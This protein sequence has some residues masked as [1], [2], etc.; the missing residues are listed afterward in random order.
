MYGSRAV[1]YGIAASSMPYQQMVSSGF[2]PQFVPMG[3]Q[4]VPSQFGPGY[5]DS[6][7]GRPA[8][9][10]GGPYDRAGSMAPLGY[11]QAFPPAGQ[12]T[13]M[14]YQPGI[15]S[16][17]QQA[18]QVIQQQQ[19]GQSLLSQQQLSLQQQ[20]LQQQALQQQAL[21]QQAQQQLDQQQQVQQHPPIP[22]YPVLSQPQ[23]TIVY[24]SPTQQ[25]PQSPASPIE[26]PVSYSHPQQF[27]LVGSTPTSPIFRNPSDQQIALQATSVQAG[28]R[29]CS[30]QLLSSPQQF[31]STSPAPQ[32]PI[33]PPYPA[34]LQPSSQANP[35]PPSYPAGVFQPFPQ[36]QNGKMVT[37]QPVYDSLNNAY[38]NISMQQIPAQMSTTSFGQER[39]A[40]P[41]YLHPIDTTVKYN[42]VSAKVDNQ[43]HALKSLHAASQD[44]ATLTAILGSYLASKRDHENKHIMTST[45]TYH[46]ARKEVQVYSHTMDKLESLS[47]DFISKHKAV[48]QPWLSALG[49]HRRHIFATLY[50]DNEIVRTLCSELSGGPMVLPELDKFAL[51]QT[52]STFNFARASIKMPNFNSSMS[53]LSQVR[54]VI[55]VDDS[56]SMVE[57]GHQ[58]WGSNSNSP[59]TRWMQAR[60][61]LSA[62][63]PLVAQHSAHGIDL[64]FLNRAPFYS[65]LRTSAA[66]EA[67]FDSDRPNNGTATGQVVND[68]LDAYMCTLRHFRKIM[69]LN[70]IVI[71]DGEAEDE[72]ILHWTIEH[73][74][75]K[76]VHR[77]FPAHQFGVEFVQVGDCR[78]ATRHLIRL[79][80]E[81]SRHHS[82][83]Q[84]DV[85]GVT[86][87][88]RI[89]GRMDAHKLLGIAVCGID[90]RMNGYMRARGVNV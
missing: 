37:S 17:I 72:N 13:Q 50:N 54:T 28:P 66:V 32:S 26:L 70:L 89:G 83:F 2:A 80:E 36:Y 15:P 9:E 19:P 88:T 8:M 35:N 5:I 53:L 75:T 49:P 55:L 21:Q 76:I 84:R 79:E 74:V 24:T 18:Y 20:A 77:G 38:S 40:P 65:G 78:H 4:M 6:G 22:V 52:I 67:A 16:T 85:V 57:P 31:Q 27:E 33:P 46:H 81:V 48:P 56:G 3:G 25:F 62:L 71:T 61:M 51:G 58:S 44:T 86:P 42:P 1:P 82:K 43:R 45:G 60:N 41:T 12:S 47:S 87:T 14:A 29:L 73:H 59:E 69:P 68:I 23:Q 64:H 39:N 10:F 63:A 90:A 30:V 34:E 11:Q 7:D